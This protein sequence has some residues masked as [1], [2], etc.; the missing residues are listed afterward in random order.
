MVNEQLTSI[1]RRSSVEA[2]FEQRVRQVDSLLM[3]KQRCDRGGSVAAVRQRAQRGEKMAILAAFLHAASDVS[4]ELSAR[5][6]G[7]TPE[8][9]EERLS[10]Q[11]RSAKSRELFRLATFRARTHGKACCG[12]HNCRDAQ[13]CDQRGNDPKSRPVAVRHGRLPV[14]PEI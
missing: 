14:A 10:R 13:R 2:R 6:C 11:T 1:R 9:R 8:H 5:G 3:T 4:A 7:D 12:F